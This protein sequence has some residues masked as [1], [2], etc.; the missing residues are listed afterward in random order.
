MLPKKSPKKSSPAVPSSAHPAEREEPTNE[1]MEAMRDPHAFLEKHGHRLADLPAPKAHHSVA[2]LAADGKSLARVLRAHSAKLLAVGLEPRVLEE[3][4]LRIALAEAAQTVRAKTS[5]A[6]SEAEKAA[7]QSATEHRAKMMK[8][9]RFALRRDTDAQAVLDRIAEGTGNADLAEDLRALC[10]VFRAHAPL[11]RKTGCDPVALTDVAVQREAGLT[12]AMG[13]RTLRAK[14][15]TREVTM[16]NQAVVY[17]LEA[18]REVR[19][20]GLFALEGDAK[21]EATLRGLA[22]LKRKGKRGA[23]LVDE[24]GGEQSAAE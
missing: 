11:V 4:P 17:A 7:V 16:R 5:G 10:E 12:E 1:S 15:G 20:A 13:T 18:I 23:V 24:D 8:I 19:D 2:S 21:M 22:S 14:G 9:A 3:L 6:L